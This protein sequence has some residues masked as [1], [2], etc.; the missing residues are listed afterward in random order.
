MNIIGYRL[1]KRILIPGKLCTRLRTQS[2]RAISELAMLAN[3]LPNEEQG[4]IFDYDNVECLLQAILKGNDQKLNYYSKAEEENKE[5][6]I[7]QKE[8][9]EYDNNFNSRIT[10]LAALLVREGIKIC[11]DQYK[12]KIEQDSTLNQAT[13]DKLKNAVEICDA[14]AFKLYSPKIELITKKQKLTYL[15]NLNRITEVSINEPSG[16]PGSDNKKLIEFLKKN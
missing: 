6:I 8:N 5:T 13:I 12:S 2:A 16:I 14:I 9:I 15:F 11:I 7:F 1:L 4:K 3:K 10:H